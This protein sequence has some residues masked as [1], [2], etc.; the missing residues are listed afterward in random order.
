MTPDTEARILVVLSEVKTGQ[1]RMQSEIKE[2]S[3]AINSTNGGDGLSEK[4]RESIRDRAA[5]HS[6]LA[7]VWTAIETINSTER[8]DAENLRVV[9]ARLSGEIRALA[10]APGN[11]VLSGVGKL[12]IGLLLALCIFLGGLLLTQLHH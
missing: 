2:L 9:D 12:S 7:E 5:I 4:A 3:A 11:V 1:E 6:E 10:A 8:N